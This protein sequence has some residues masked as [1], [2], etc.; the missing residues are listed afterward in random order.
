MTHCTHEWTPVPLEIGRYA[1]T[2][3]GRVG[4]RTASG[5]RALKRPQDDL[6]EAIANAEWSSARDAAALA[7]QRGRYGVDCLWSVDEE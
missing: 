7:I 5:I 4:C 2:R 3:C 6:R 1:C